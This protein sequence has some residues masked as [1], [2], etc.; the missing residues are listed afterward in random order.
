[1]LVDP[2]LARIRSVGRVALWVVLGVLLG[3][4]V[5]TAAIALTNW[6]HIGV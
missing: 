3:S 6:R 5:Y 4:A 2:S 1:M